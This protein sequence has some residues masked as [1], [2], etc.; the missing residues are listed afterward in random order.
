MSNQEAAGLPELNLNGMQVWLSGAVPESE[1]PS[2]DTELAIE[3]WHG[4]SLEHGILGFVQEFSSL[5]FKCGGRIIHGAH[6]TLT[7]ILLEQARAFWTTTDDKPLLL[8]VSDH[9]ETEQRR[10]EWR[11]WERDAD[12]DVVPGT[13][14]TPDQRDPS[15]VILRD[16]LAEHCD[17]FVAI[18]G[19]WWHDVPGRAGIPMEFERAKEARVPCFIL[20]GFGGASRTYMEEHPDWNNDLN[21]GLTQE[22]N[23]AVARDTNFV[24][25]AGRLVSQ[26]HLLNSQGGSNQAAFAD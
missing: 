13:G 25:T 24:L 9:F 5:V 21:N 22:Q 19:L 7:P 8:A 15:L 20:G 16:H 26:L 4:S 23:N 1:Q 10:A 6:P 3:V 17:A 11:R 12:V 2:P 14:M 18:G